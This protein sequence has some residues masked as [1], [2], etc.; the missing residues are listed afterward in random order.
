MKDKKEDNFFKELFLSIEKSAKGKDKLSYTK[1]LVK[2]GKNKIRRRVRYSYCY[3][4]EGD[5]RTSCRDCYGLCW[6]T[7]DRGFTH[8][9]NDKG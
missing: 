1:Y 9:E 2:E 8:P 5:R 6:E 7:W 4:H 3:N